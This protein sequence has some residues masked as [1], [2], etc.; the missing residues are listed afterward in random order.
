MKILKFK[1]RDELIQVNPDDI[2]YFK[3]DGNFTN[4][5]LVSTEEKL[6]SMNLSALQS[7]L[8]EQLGIKAAIFERVGRKL[9]IRKSYLFSLHVVQKKI[10]LIAPNGN[11]FTETES[12]DAIKSLKEIQEAET[13]KIITTAQLR[14]IATGN[15]YR[16]NMGMNRFGRKSNATLC[17]HPIDNGDS[18]ISRNHFNIEIKYDEAGEIEYSM[19]DYQSANGTYLNDTLM[20]KEIS[21]N[22]SFGTKIKAGKTEFV[23]EKA[24]LE[25]TEIV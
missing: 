3:A 11:K 10:T 14:D 24:D 22:L 18:Q 1:G 5:V 21:L 6:L 13:S 19:S 20:D 17:E 15:V 2:V 23:F 4:M 9:V 7:T 8:K 16:L 25:K 12:R